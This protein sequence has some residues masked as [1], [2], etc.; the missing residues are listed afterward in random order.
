[1]ILTALQVNVARTIG[2]LRDVSATKSLSA[3]VSEVMS[4]VHSEV[5]SEVISEV[6]SF[7]NTDVHSDDYSDRC[8][9][10]ANVNDN[11]N[12]EDFFL[13]FQMGFLA[14]APFLV[15]G[16]CTPMSGLSA[17]ILRKSR[18]STSIV[19]KVFYAVGKS[20]DL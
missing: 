18:A 4:D 2:I 7:F 16:L 8:N 20:L 5:N 13:F 17:D 11:F 1:M 6:N 19:R 14:A 12:I 9:S 10:S 3:S 15:K